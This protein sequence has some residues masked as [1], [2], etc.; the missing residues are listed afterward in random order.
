MEK[1]CKPLGDEPGEI[2][3]PNSLSLSVSALS[4]SVFSVSVW[5]TSQKKAIVVPYSSFLSPSSGQVLV[6]STSATLTSKASEASPGCSSEKSH[7]FF[8]PPESQVCR[9]PYV[10]QL[11]CVQHHR[12]SQ[13][14]DCHDVKLVPGGMPQP[15]RSP[16]STFVE[17]C[18]RCLFKLFSFPDHYGTVR[19]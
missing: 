8:R 16:T 3:S 15:S 10:W 11:L 19:C 4:V 7:H 5:E 12:P 2:P 17:I 9:T 1:I 14:A 18:V 6:S 13:H